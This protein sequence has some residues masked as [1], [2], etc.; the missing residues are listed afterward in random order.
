MG[1]L[2]VHAGRHVMGTLQVHAGRHVMGTLQVHAGRHV[3]GTLQVHAVIIRSVGGIVV[4]NTTC[5]CDACFSNCIVEP[6]C[7]GWK[8]QSTVK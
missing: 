3:M 5:F 2:Q 4:K 8:I 6:A 1:T 7:E